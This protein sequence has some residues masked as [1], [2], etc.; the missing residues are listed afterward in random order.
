MPNHLK[1]TAIML[2]V[3]LAFAG[4]HNIQGENMKNSKVEYIK[5]EGKIGEMQNHHGYNGAVIINDSI[6]KI[7][8]QGGWDRDFNFPHKDLKDEINQAFE[9]VAFALESA[10][11][12]W[13]KVYS[14]TTYFT[15]KITE[16]INQ[17]MSQQFKSRCQ[18]LPLWTSVQVAGLGDPRM[19]VEVVVEAYK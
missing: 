1:N 14:V 12:D 15:G 16:E 2:C 11:S 4:C 9:N 5:L 10:G 17:T 13:S 3:M 6:V 19:R 7:S 18:N 8:G